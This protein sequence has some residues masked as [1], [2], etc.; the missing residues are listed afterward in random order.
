MNTKNVAFV[1]GNGTSRKSI[2]LDNLK[3]HGT[4]YACNAI[5]REFSPDYLIAVD[6]KMIVEI[7]RSGYHKNSPVWTNYNR[8]YEK[9]NC[10]NYFEPSKGWSSGPTA[11]DMASNHQYQTIFILGFDYV[12]LGNSVNNI[13]AGTENYKGKDQ[14][15]TYYGNWLRQTQTVIKKNSKIDYIRVVEEN[16]FIPKEFVNLKNLKHFSI[17]EFQKIFEQN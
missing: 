17:E 16:G 13:Y 10:L 8:S 9:F 14:T 1:L 3:R 4:V 5:Y 12:G 11:L 2:S 6:T 15:A 7:V